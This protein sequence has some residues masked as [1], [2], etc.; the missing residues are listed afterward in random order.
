MRAFSDI[1]AVAAER[2][3]GEAALETLVAE[4]TSKSRAELTSTPDDRWLAQMTKVVFQA[5]FNWKVIENKWPGF[6]TAFHGFEPKL[7]AAMSD[8][9]FDVHLK[10]TRIIRNAQKILSVRANAQFL[11]DLATEHGSA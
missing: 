1:Y 10:D 7:N 3:G 2:K 6:E 9:E 5:G 11:V 8:D 4:S